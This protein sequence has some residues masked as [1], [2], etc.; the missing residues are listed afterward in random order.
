MS[1][2]TTPLVTFDYTAWSALFPT[3]AASVSQPQAQLYFNLAQDFCDNTAL[4][5]LVCD[6]RRLTDVLNLLTAHIALL[7]QGING[8]N[9][10]V[11]RISNATE[12]SVSVAV[13]MPTTMNAAWFNQT[14]PGAMAWQAMAPYRTAL[15]VAAPQIPLSAQSLPGFPGFNL[16]PFNGGFPW[17]R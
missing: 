13:E 1:Q 11:G 14:Q 9:S 17:R 2:A 5:Q 15:Y 8:N 4:S 6:L 3:L 12:G 16:L 7:F 10:I